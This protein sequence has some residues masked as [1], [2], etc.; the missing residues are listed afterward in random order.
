MF[1]RIF[2]LHEHIFP[3]ASVLLKL[4]WFFG[5]QDVDAIVRT[6]L[7]GGLSA[8]RA[9]CRA[10]RKTE[11]CLR[12]NH[13]STLLGGAAHFGL[14]RRGKERRRREDPERNLND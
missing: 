5:P 10:S 1:D 12:A 11:K 4:G 3:P 6:A 8:E 9:V 7:E 14:R 2:I 13:A